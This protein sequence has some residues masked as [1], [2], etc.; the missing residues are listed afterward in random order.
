MQ[1]ACLSLF[2][3]HTAANGN[4]MLWLLSALLC[5][6]SADYTPPVYTVDLTQPAQT[7]WNHIYP[8]YSSILKQVI[9]EALGQLNSFETFLLANALKLHYIDKETNG[10]IEGCAKFLDVS[11][12]E[13]AVMQF[14]Y[15]LLNGCTSIIY[16]QANNTIIHG[17]NLD[18]DFA[19][20]LREMVINV[21][22][23]RGQEYVFTATT[24]PCYFGVIS[25]SKPGAFSVSVDERY[26]SSTKSGEII[27]L[28]RN[29]LGLVTFREGN[30]FVLRRAME[31]YDSWKDAVHYLSTVPIVA[32]TYYIVAGLTDNEGVVITRNRWDTANYWY[33]NSTSWFLVETNYDHWKPQPSDDDRADPAIRMMKALGQSGLNVASFYNL[34]DTYPVLQQN[35]TVYTTI[36]SPATGFYD[37]LVRENATSLA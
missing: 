22:F 36:M 14:L 35:L 4:K 26:D 8:A 33:L 2:S 37:T 19:P 23:Y 12:N 9:S 7:R 1:K 16:R 25:G 30:T 34:F 10:E 28:V 18:F 6:V 29:L 27:S 11:Y 20:L 24:F 5:L 21:E 13:V 32:P 17:R 31:T 15:E 3:L